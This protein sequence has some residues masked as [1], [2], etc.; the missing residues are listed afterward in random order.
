ML[1]VLQRLGQSRRDGALHLHRSSTSTSTSRRDGALHLHRRH[2]PL[3]M[4][5]ASR[6]VLRTHHSL[7]LRLL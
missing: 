2:V 7:H 6:H 3:L 1:A 5:D 4:V